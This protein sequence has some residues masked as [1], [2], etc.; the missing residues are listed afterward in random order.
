MAYFDVV[1]VGFALCIGFVLMVSNFYSYSADLAITEHLKRKY[2]PLWN[3]LSIDEPTLLLISTSVLDS[4]ALDRIRSECQGDG[5]L[6]SLVKD[7]GHARR[8]AL[9]SRVAMLVWVIVV[10][11]RETS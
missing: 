4:S 5:R 11:I 9:W 10:V 7:L 1:I 6:T 2:L 8:L 3:E